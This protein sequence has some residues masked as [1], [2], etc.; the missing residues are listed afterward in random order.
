MFDCLIL[1]K[2]YIDPSAHCLETWTKREMNTFDEI[3]LMFD[4]AVGIIVVIWTALWHQSVL[5]FRKG[6]ARKLR[7]AASSFK[8]LC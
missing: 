3:A 8:R 1:R 6:G 4:D 7:E 5:Q 2:A